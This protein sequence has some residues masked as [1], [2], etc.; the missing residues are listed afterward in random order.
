MTIW[1]LCLGLNSCFPAPSRQE[2]YKGLCARRVCDYKEETP[3]QRSQVNCPAARSLSLGLHCRHL[4]FCCGCFDVAILKLRTFWY[5]Y[6]NAV[7]IF[8]LF[9][10]TSHWTSMFWKNYQV[11]DQGQGKMV[12]MM[13]KTGGRVRLWM[14]VHFLFTFCIGKEEKS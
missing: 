4:T 2:L 14:G 9:E 10:N 7:E 6:F 5:S 11:W 8:W 1:R 13:E 3:A 12:N